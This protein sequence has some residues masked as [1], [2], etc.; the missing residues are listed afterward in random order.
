MQN[1]EKRNL[2]IVL[3]FCVIAV[4]LLW[5]IWVYYENRLEE[6]DRELEIIQL[7]V[8][9]TFGLFVIYKND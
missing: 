5:A 8:I 2:I 4:A 9:Y 1:N 3:T 6:I 7:G